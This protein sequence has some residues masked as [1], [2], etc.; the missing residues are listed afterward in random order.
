[1]LRIFFYSFL[2]LTGASCFGHSCISTPIIFA[3]ESDTLII[4]TDTIFIE[5]DQVQLPEDS[6]PGESLK[7]TRV[8]SHPWSAS[9]SFGVNLTHAQILSN[10]ND[11][12]TI[13][14]FTGLP[15]RPQ[16]NVLIGADLGYRFLTIPTNAGGI[17]LS[18]ISGYSLNKI[19]VGFAS[20]ENPSD[21]NRDS[22]L[23]FNN[24]GGEL[25]LGYFMITDPPFIG[26]VDST[27]LFLNKQRIDYQTHDVT[28]K[29]R[30]TL[31]KGPRRARLFL[32]TGV[33]R[34]FVRLKDAAQDLYVLNENGTYYLLNPEQIT[35]RN[36]LVPHFAVG[37]E[38]RFDASSVNQD[39]YF[40]L[41]SSF[42]AS[43]P[44]AAFYGNDFYSVE[45]RNYA[46][47]VVARY[48]F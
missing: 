46:W 18:A 35:G 10:S 30:A 17:D 27:Y 20:I 23:F 3:L 43:F 41:G 13:N 34:R 5:Q 2:L 15:Y 8:K 32:E 42:S 19:S 47:S 22:L 4:D 7:R 31:N 12:K 14:D 16:P 25:V 33:V 6:L 40:T 24:E 48:F 39:N 44:S 21:L 38:K 9:L 26:E 36:L 37:F 1:M 45:I 11:Y 29:L 28:A